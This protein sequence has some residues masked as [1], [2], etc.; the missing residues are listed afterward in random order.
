[1][2]IRRKDENY[3]KYWQRKEKKSQLTYR[4]GHD[5]L[6]IK[7]YLYSINTNNNCQKMKITNIKFDLKYN[8]MTK[9]LE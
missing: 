4:Y 5:S 8:F 6:E 1:M 7:I 2:P 3:Q 9:I